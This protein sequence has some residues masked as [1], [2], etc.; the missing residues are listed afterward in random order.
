MPQPLQ[1]VRV[2]AGVVNH[3]HCVHLQYL[4][5]GHHKELLNAPEH[6]IY[7][8]VWQSVLTQ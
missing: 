6:E 2:R 8:P 3:S 5:E 7:A 1:Y 4:L